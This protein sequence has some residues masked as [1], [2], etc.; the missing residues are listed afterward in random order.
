MMNHH[1]APCATIDVSS[2]A[3]VFVDS[4]LAENGRRLFFAD[5]VPEYVAA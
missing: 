5:T 2:L 3:P 1:T 4:V